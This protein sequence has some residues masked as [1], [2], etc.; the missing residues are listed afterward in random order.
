MEINFDFLVSG[1]N[2]QCRHCYVNGGPGPLMKTD[3]ALACV[4]KLDQIAQF[5]PKGTSFT[6]DHEPMNHPE[7]GK[8][9]SAAA[10]TKYIQNGHHGMTTGAGLMAR[11]DKEAVVKAYRE[12]GYNNFGITIHGISAHHDEIVRRKGAFDKAIAA[13]RFLSQMG[14]KVQLSLMMNRY[15]AEDAEQ[16]SR[17]IDDIG[18]DEIFFA[19]PIFTPHANMMAFEPYRATLETFEKIYHYLPQWNQN[20]E[21][22]MESARKNSI[23]AAGERLQSM[24]LR[25]L[26]QKKQDTLFLTL[27]QDCTLYVGN[28][29]VETQLLGDLRELEPEA[30]AEIIQKLPGNFDYGAFYEIVNIPDTERILKAMKAIPQNLVYGDF[31]SALY[32]AFVELSIPTKLLAN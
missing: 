21:E 2:T 25:K 13:A 1:C 11:S 29:G 14:C 12:N 6:L 30:V 22:I 32:R 16:I 8:I 18:F 31:A 23:G 5:L 10:H 9:L 7:I 24:D 19:I 17:L 4:K 26:W 27:H 3:D 15:F 28:S 20:A